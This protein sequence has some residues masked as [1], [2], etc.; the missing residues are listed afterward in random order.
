MT[1]SKGLHHTRLTIEGTRT[2]SHRLSSRQRRGTAVRRRHIRLRYGFHE[3]D[4]HYGNRS[5]AHRI[6][7]RSETRWFVA[8]LFLSGTI[9]NYGQAPSAGQTTQTPRPDHIILISVDG[10]P[11]DYYTAPEKLG[12]RVPTMTMMKQGGAYA[13]GM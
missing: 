5:P 10:M 7:S 2:V 13:D 6:L 9:F 3:L 1:E 4:G 12:L 8:L 11:P